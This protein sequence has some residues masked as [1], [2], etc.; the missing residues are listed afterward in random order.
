MNAA[1][2]LATLVATS[3]VSGSCGP[4]GPVA[5]IEQS[6]PAYHWQHTAYRTW[7]LYYGRTVVGSWD[8]TNCRYVPWDA[9][10][11]TWAASS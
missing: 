4:V 8:E 5:Q 7:E 1:L 6:A 11:R 10:S 9:R 2:L 3:W